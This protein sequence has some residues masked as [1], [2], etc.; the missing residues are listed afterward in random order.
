MFVYSVYRP[1]QEGSKGSDEHG[2][3]VSH[4]LISRIYTKL[5]VDKGPEYVLFI[6][7]DV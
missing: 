7:M 2:H 5:E 6:I 4:F 3:M 1:T